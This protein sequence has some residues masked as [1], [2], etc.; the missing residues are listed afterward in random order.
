MQY[1]ILKLMDKKKIIYDLKEV[2]FISFQ[3]TQMQFSLIQNPL[4]LVNK[5]FALMKHFSLF[6]SILSR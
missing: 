2:K 5:R 1:T 4:N 6:F 3:Q